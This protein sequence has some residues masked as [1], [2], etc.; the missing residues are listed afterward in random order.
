MG[1]SVGG[2]EICKESTSLLC[3]KRTGVHGALRECSRDGEKSTGKREYEEN[4]HQV[5]KR[6]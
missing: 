1:D 5:K 4:N 3:V 2:R 6:G